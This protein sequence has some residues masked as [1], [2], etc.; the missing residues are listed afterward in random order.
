M[1][2]ADE[3]QS[4]VKLIDLGSAEDFDHLDIRRMRIDD[5]PKRMQHL[6]FVGT[7]QYM[8]PE[9]VRNKGSYLAMDVWSLGCIL[10]QFYRGKLPF[11]GKSDYFIFNKSVE[12]MY[13]LWEIPEDI[14]PEKAKKLIDRCI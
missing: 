11:T 5:N 4:K 14:I 2:F 9:A 8:A 12:A 13:K 7:P 3:A 6:N 1:F 10:Y